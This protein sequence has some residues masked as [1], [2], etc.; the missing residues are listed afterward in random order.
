VLV[1]D[2]VD[3]AP[4]TF[5][6]AE[7]REL[8]NKGR[9]RFADPDSP[10]PGFRR[11]YSADVEFVRVELQPFID[12]A[13]AALTDEQ[14]R[15]EYDRQVADGLWRTPNTPPT[16][17]PA[18]AGDATAPNAGD[19][20]NPSD[21]ADAPVDESTVENEPA[22]PVDPEPA[23]TDQPSEAT[24]PQDPV[25][26]QTEPQSAVGSPRA[27]RLVD[28]Q[29]PTQPPAEDAADTS[30]GQVAEAVETGDVGQTP[31]DENAAPP[32]VDAAAPGSDPSEV[33]SANATADSPESPASQP[34]TIATGEGPV[35]PSA[36][37]PNTRVQTFDE[38][39][40]Q[41]REQMA[42]QPARDAMRQVIDKI[43][44][45]MRGFAQ[46]HARYLA[47]K[48]EQADVEAPARLNLQ[49]IAES[50]GVK[51]G[52]T[53][54]VDALSVGSLPISRSA[55]F[56][57]AGFMRFN[58]MVFNQDVNDFQIQESQDFTDGATY[59]FWRTESR[60]DYTPKLEDVREEVI[61]FL[62]LKAARELARKEAE[63]L[64]KR[65]NEQ[66]DRPLAE[67]VPE[68][69]ANLVLTEVGPFSWFTL[70]SQLNGQPVISE[71]PELDRVGDEFMR[72]VF[73]DNR[74]RWQVAGNAPLNTYYVLRGSDFQ[75]GLEEL[76]K[77]FRETGRRLAGTTVGQDRVSAMYRA[78]QRSITDRIGLE[79]EPL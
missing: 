64:A 19:A 53:G 46:K 43:R 27:V 52:Q 70:V 41:V 62:R 38:V 1:A 14:V 57:D 68:N 72:A 34:P 35:N 2:Y 16:T 50:Y 56:T 75:P 17:P 8:F 13:K 74:D 49:Q 29:A 42:L 30:T 31:V 48:R 33:E 65:A 11:R 66:P 26:P 44:K 76:Q 21:A 28:Y 9:D 37:S 59:V 12:Q 22:A 71:V 54:M 69:R 4:A 10:D 79:L 7:I 45:E 15:A 47:Q 6:E 73:G 60:D 63:A 67:L 36:I 32:R 78:W 77:Q 39:K 40:D 3:K 61:S 25:A 51:F 58:Q 24:A 20:A 23:A 5:T 55:S 18:P